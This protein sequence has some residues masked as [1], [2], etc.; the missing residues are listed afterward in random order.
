MKVVK[1]AIVMIMNMYFNSNNNGACR[2]RAKRGAMLWLML[3]MPLLLCAQYKSRTDN[4]HFFYVSMGAGYASVSDTIKGVSPVGG[5]GALAGIGYEFRRTGFWMSVG[6]Q[7]Q[8]HNTSAHVEDFT[9]E[10][11]GLDTQEPRKSVTLQYTFHEEDE[12][13]FRF[14]DVP[15]ML[16]YYYNGFY[17]GLGGKVAFSMKSSVSTSGSFDMNAVYKQYV[18]MPPVALDNSLFSGRQDVRLK[19]AGALIGEVGYDV[20]AT[21]RS[22]ERI[23]HMLKIGAYFEYGINSV[24]P[25]VPEGDQGRISFPNLNEYGE[26]IATK[27][28]VR[29]VYAAVM[30][31]QR[32]AP[33]I[34]GLKF[35][36]MFGGSRTGGSGTWHRGCQCYD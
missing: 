35:T 18:D 30:S 4:Y 7:V 3:A 15:V 36:Y 29:P 16:G 23:C 17:A 6:A 2:L 28:Q 14:V 26:I 5:W 27:P 10:R 1:T 25:S 32:V 8:M 34:I 13:N 9:C 24:S 19:V 12:Q 33:Y 21:L 11:E 22:H 20:L 31:G